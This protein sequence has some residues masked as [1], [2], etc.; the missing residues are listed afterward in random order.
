MGQF[1]AHTSEPKS[2]GNDA[3]SNVWLRRLLLCID[4]H[5]DGHWD[6]VFH[7]ITST[8]FRPPPRVG[9]LGGDFIVQRNHSHVGY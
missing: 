8:I 2:A 9:A 5:W 3:E 1:F 7:I 6:C 4:H